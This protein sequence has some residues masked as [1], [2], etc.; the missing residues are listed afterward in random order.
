MLLFS[1]LIRYYNPVCYDE[2]FKRKVI[3]KFLVESRVRRPVLH[4]GLKDLNDDLIVGRGEIYILLVGYEILSERLMLFFR[5]RKNIVFYFLSE[6]DSEYYGREFGFKGE[7]VK[8]DFVGRWSAERRL[9]F[10]Y[11][12]GEIGVNKDFRDYIEGS[13]NI[14]MDVCKIKLTLM[15]SLRSI[16]DPFLNVA[17][18]CGVEMEYINI[19]YLKF[20]ELLGI[21][22][23]KFDDFEEKYYFYRNHFLK[24]SN[25]LY[26]LGDKVVNKVFDIKLRDKIDKI[27]ELDGKNVKKFVVISDSIDYLRGCEKYV[28]KILVNCDNLILKKVENNF[29]SVNKYFFDEIVFENLKKYHNKIASNENDIKYLNSSDIRIYQFIISDENDIKY[30]ENYLKLFNKYKVEIPIEVYSDFGVELFY[31]GDIS[32]YK[33]DEFV[34]KDYCKI[35]YSCNLDKY[36]E[37]LVLRDSIELKRMG[38]II[39]LVASTQYPYYG[40]AS[41]NAYNIIKYL[42]ASE[43]ID[44]YGMFVDSCDGIEVKANPEGIGGVIGVNYGEFS[45]IDIQSILLGRLGGMPDIAFCK[46]CLAPK[47]VK[48]AFPT[49]INIFLVSG[50]LGFSQLECGAKEIKDFSVIRRQQEEK[51]IE[52]AD[53]IICNSV[54]TIGYFRK[55]YF[56]SRKKLLGIPVDT[57][58]YNVMNKLDEKLDRDIDIIVISSNVNRLV[59]NI[60]FFRKMLGVGE[61]LGGYRVVVVGENGEEMFK[62]FSNVEVYPLIA[63]GDVRRLLLRS[64]VIVI[65]SLFD[66]NSNVFRE[67]VYSGVIP[68]ISEN[69][70]CPMDYP[71]FLVM[72]GYDELSWVDRLCYLLDNYGMVVGRYRLEGIFEG[73]DDLMDFI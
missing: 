64:K 24:V 42:R 17:I 36:F 14:F 26:L 54:L 46:N 68:L 70:S 66:S 62:D 71:N 22:R 21:F 39:V 59:K 4:I 41:T 38:K 52:V 53:L 11:G 43:E 58:K 7:V 31:G 23:R 44:V 73:D 60:G 55:I 28:L 57:T 18:S 33:L 3:D 48:I 20:N 72:D 8:I 19:N 67:A 9:V 56:D 51:A 37:D 69:V 10:F 1:Q 45:Y 35:Y 5:G 25:Y 63:Q 49:A 32:Y 27:Y 61:R 30:V 50:I 12:G 15:E 2:L 34:V 13:D 16:Y 6:V 29:I 65:P 47:L 40:G